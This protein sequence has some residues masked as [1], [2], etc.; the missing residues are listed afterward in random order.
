MGNSGTFRKGDGRPRKPVG[1][2]NKVTNKAR[3]AFALAFE[4]IGGVR[5]LMEWAHNNP[6]EF[7]KLY[8]RLIP[9]DVTTGEREIRVAFVQANGND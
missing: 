8:A 6:D 9:Q 3:E 4:G 2:V 5:A 1:A 7:Y